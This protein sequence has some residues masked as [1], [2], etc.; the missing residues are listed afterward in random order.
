M[1][2]EVADDRVHLDAV[3]LARDR[4]GGVAQ[5]LL[6]HVEGHEAIERAR[7]AERVE[8]E[9]G[10]LRRARPELDERVG[11]GQLGDV[12]RVLERGSTRSVRVG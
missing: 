5:R 12:A 6:A 4:G 3:V 8:Q 11:L 10:L 7:V 2:L 1:V 9:P